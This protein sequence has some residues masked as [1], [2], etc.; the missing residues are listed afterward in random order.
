M[1]YKAPCS[2]HPPSCAPALR[3][4]QGQAL[5]V[6]RNLDAAGRGRAMEPAGSEGMPLLPH[7]GN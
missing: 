7:Q 1:N 2:S 3:W 4:H 6:L 5:R